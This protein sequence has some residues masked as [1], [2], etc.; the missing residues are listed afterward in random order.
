M[1]GAGRSPNGSLGP[2]TQTGIADAS[3]AAAA[4]AALMSPAVSSST[5]TV[6]TCSAAGI[7][8]ATASASIAETSAR[9]P[10]GPG[11]MTS[12][13]S[14]SPRSAALW[15]SRA[16]PTAAPAMPSSGR[17][18]TIVA[19]KHRRDHTA[20]DAPLEARP[21]AVIGHLL[22]VELALVVRFDHEDAVD[23]EEPRDL[24]VDEIVVRAH[25]HRLVREPGE[26]ERMAPLSSDGALG[27]DTVRR[28]RL[29]RV[30]FGHIDTSAPR[31]RRMVPWRRTVSR[32]QG[33]CGCACDDRPGTS[34]ACEATRTF[35]P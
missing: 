8:R 1:S 29:G 21:G 5:G 14:F 34:T 26:D 13:S 30:W 9:S 2:R 22:D 4:A 6:L 15:R 28:R 24:G 27:D 7:F 10:E 23:L 17:A 25:R 35:A 16:L 20:D 33:M 31:D 12:A 18:T 32:A 19:G 11:A 3:C